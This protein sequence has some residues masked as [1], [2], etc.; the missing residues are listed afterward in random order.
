LEPARLFR[1]FFELIERLERPEPWLETKSEP[2]RKLRITR[3]DDDAA[4]K[5]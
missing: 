3:L 1:R 2:Q 4:R 5:P